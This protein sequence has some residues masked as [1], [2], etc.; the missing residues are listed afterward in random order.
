MLAALAICV[1]LG[2]DSG[3]RNDPD[4][5]DQ[6]TS[7]VQANMDLLAKYKSVP[8]SA[9]I[10][11][12]SKDQKKLLP[13]LM[14]ASDAMDA[15][16]WQQAYG[17]KVSLLDSIEDDA[18]RRFAE[19]NYGPWDRLDNNAPFLDGVGAKPA[20][21]NFY[22]ADMTRAEFERASGQNA[23][24]KSL[25][26]VVR[27]DDAGQLIAVP[28][29]QAY[30]D[31]MHKAAEYLRE[32]GALA[33]DEEFGAYLKLRAAAL[34]SD[35][36]FESDLAW[37]SMKNNVIDIVI[38]PIEVYEDELFGYK[39]GAESYVLIKDVEWS[40]RLAVYAGLLPALQR[41]L[42]VEDR[43]RAE[44]P[45]SE[46][47][48]NAYDLIYVTGH[49][50]AGSK[51]I[52]I[53]LPNDERVQLEKGSRRLQLK[54]AMRAKF[55]EILIPIADELIADDQ[56]SHIEFDAF[57]MNTMLHEVAHGLGLKNTVGENPVTV[58][59]AMQEHYSAIEEGKADILGLYM[60][61]A[62]KEMGELDTDLMD[63]YVTFLAGIFRS[64]RFGASS[65]HGTA[66]MIRFNFFEEQGAFTR[67]PSG[68][69]RVN[70]DVMRT[71]TD[72]LSAQ[73]LRLQGNGDKQ[74]AAEFVEKYATVGE[75]LQADL[76][77]LSAVGIPVDVV[78]Q[79]GMSE[80]H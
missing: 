66:N 36:Y 31:H 75:Q 29:S 65:A 10:S 15:I 40:E 14:R 26:T 3:L 80:L 23:A 49:A 30:A 11:H 56:R 28:Y 78:F 5:L 58:R 69:Y 2:C 9:D 63:N 45:G 70:F 46:S 12:L 73:I 53:N 67:E 43:Y 47:D 51:T 79:Q 6:I 54:N 33:V 1:A 19:I 74:A 18:L 68:K 38:G 13:L 22:P 44:N 72:S 34:E 52:A 32:A 24:L 64:V 37:M 55:D 20:G 25:Y 71:A 8:L 42:P 16:F 39:A 17:D 7:P 62:L 77:R 48:L 61:A 35:E 59:E 76:D 41:G 60:V 27:R 21:A 57:F 4:S 50:N